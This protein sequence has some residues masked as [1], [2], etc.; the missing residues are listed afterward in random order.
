MRETNFHAHKKLTNITVLFILIFTLSDSK[1]NNSNTQVL[2]RLLQEHTRHLHF[3]NSCNVTSS[4]R[5][6]LL[7]GSTAPTGP[8]PLHCPYIE[9]TL[10]HITLCRTHLDEGSAR[11]RHLYLTTHNTQNRQT[12]ITPAGFEPAIPASERPQTHALDLAVTGIFP[13][14]YSSALKICCN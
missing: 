6:F 3:R 8:W 11:R 7:P 10:I 1:P 12:S 5:M 4:T 14:T 9:I 2:K 13:G